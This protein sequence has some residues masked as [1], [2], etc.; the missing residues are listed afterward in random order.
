MCIMGAIWA[1]LVCWKCTSMAGPFDK[2][3]L[4]GPGQAGATEHVPLR[5]AWIE[6]SWYSSPKFFLQARPDSSSKPGDPRRSSPRIHPPRAN[7]PLPSRS[8][9]S[10]LRRLLRRCKRRST[11]PPQSSRRSPNPHPHPHPFRLPPPRTLSDTNT[12]TAPFHSRRRRPS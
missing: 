9:I 10:G 3:G 11:P 12:A 6:L 4:D 8:Y 2:L 5:P 7:L 1:V